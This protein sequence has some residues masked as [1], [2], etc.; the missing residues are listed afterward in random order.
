[1]MACEVTRMVILGQKFEK[2]EPMLEL[3]SDYKS[4]I[5]CELGWRS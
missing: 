3:L 5:D 2:R 4:V 1:M